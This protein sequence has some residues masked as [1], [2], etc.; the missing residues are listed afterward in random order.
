MITHQENIKALTGVVAREGEAII[1]R[2][3]EQGL[4][5]LGRVIFN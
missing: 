3:T 5:V 2:P 1:V 4:H